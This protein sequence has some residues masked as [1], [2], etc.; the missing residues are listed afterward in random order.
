MLESI[1]VKLESPI[2]SEKSNLSETI[3]HIELFAPT[4]KILSQCM[5]IK[6][7]ATKGIIALTSINKKS[8]DN[9]AQSEASESNDEEDKENLVSAYKQA[10]MMCDEH[11][12]VIDAF[13]YILT[14]KFGFFNIGGNNVVVGPVV[15]DN[16]STN[17]TINLMAEYIANFLSQ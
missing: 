12:K 1:K 13:Y 2:A 6:S 16:L 15:Y 5:I 9:S 7:Q 4:N 11:Q 17:D 8:S 10:I 14:N 3:T